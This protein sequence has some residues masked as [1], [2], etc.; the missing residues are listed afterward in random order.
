MEANR[1][2][3]KVKVV[4][5]L[6]ARELLDGIEQALTAH[7]ASGYTVGH[8]DGRGRHGARFHGWLSMG[9]VRV[10][11]LLRSE[12]AKSFLEQLLR[13]YRGREL[14]AFSQDAEAIPPEHFA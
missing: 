3:A 1:E 10:E 5:I 8:V 7:G 4:T 12:G 2:P 13:E 11:A 6:A 14:V 9:N